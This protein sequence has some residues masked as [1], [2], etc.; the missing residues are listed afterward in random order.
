MSYWDHIDILCIQFLILIFYWHMYIGYQHASDVIPNSF[1]DLRGTYSIRSNISIILMSYVCRFLT[2]SIYL[3]ISYTSNI[4]IILISWISHCLA[5]G[6]LC[7]RYWHY[8]DILFISLFRI[9]LE[10]HNYIRYWCCVC[11]IPM[12]VLDII[13]NQSHIYFQN[14]HHIGI[15]CMLF[16]DIGLD[17]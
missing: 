16:F 14:W 17:T 13:L 4:D 10:C 12:S 2:L 11:I 8:I 15:L 6:N 1:C 5:L 7:I 3:I 9:S